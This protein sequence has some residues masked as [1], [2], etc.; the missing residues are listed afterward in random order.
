M[1]PLLIDA[2]LSLI[3]GASVSSDNISVIWHDYDTPPVTEAE[4]N[5]EYQRLLANYEENEYQRLR[6]VEYPQ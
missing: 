2:A 5:A 6:A 4:L 3:P 1:K